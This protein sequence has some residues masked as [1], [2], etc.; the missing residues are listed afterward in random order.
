MTNI[1]EDMILIA[2]NT[3][4]VFNE[5]IWVADSGATTHVTNSLDGMFDL[6]DANTT[7]SVGDGRKMMTLKVGK[8][9]GKAID[10]EGNEVKVILTNVSYVPEL[11]VNLFSLTAV[12]E[13]GISVIGEKMASL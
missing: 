8:W 7:I 9:K 10:S 12:M 4:K 6:R 11:M 2:D 1:Q 3:V 13:K 5:R